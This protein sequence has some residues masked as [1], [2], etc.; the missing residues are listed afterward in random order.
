MIKWVKENQLEFFDRINQKK[1][2]CVRKFTKIEP[3]LHEVINKTHCLTR[4]GPV[5]MNGRIECL[6]YFREF[7]L[8]MNYHRYGNL[9]NREEEVRKLVG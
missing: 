9:C 3:K 6:R 7:S 4:I 2:T 8:S 5:L 1:V